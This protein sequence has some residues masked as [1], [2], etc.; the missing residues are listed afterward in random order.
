MPIVENHIRKWQEEYKIEFPSRN[1]PILIKDSNCKTCC[2]IRFLKALN[3]PDFDK[4]IIQ[5]PM[6]NFC[7]RLV[8]LIPFKTNAYYDGIW[9]TSDVIKFYTLDKV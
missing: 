1:F 8:S 7:M 9:L 5:A 2:I 3:P 4:D 6:E